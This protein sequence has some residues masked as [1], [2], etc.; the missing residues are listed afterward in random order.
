[1]IKTIL[2]I[3]DITFRNYKNWIKKYGK[4]I[5][6]IKVDEVI[7]GNEIYDFQKLEK[8]DFVSISREP[9]VASNFQKRLQG[10]TGI[11]EG[12]RGKSYIIKIRDHNEYKKLLIEPIHLKKIKQIKHHDKK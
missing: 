5:K 4:Y 7:I 8:G 2:F 10:I 6:D 9:A 1:M 12:K 11:V 3:P